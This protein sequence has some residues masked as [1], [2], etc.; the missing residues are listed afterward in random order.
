MKS[1]IEDKLKKC[2]GGEVC[3]PVGGRS[4]LDLLNTYEHNGVCASD[5]SSGRASNADRV[6]LTCK[7][8]IE[9]R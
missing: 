7:Y 5:L 4:G 2:N 1:F 6:D 8:S 9:Y 3:S